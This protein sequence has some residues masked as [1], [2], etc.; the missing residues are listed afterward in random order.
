MSRV[1]TAQAKSRT[2]CGHDNRDRTREVVVGLW[3]RRLGNEL[4]H[5]GE[6][7]DVGLNLVDY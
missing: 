7:L 4:V 2:V 1:G 3:R 6:E 5:Q